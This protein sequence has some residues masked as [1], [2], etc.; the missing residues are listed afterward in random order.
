MLLGGSFYH[1]LCYCNI[2]W[3]FGPW[4]VVF[5][6]K[7][8]ENFGTNR[9]SIACTIINCVAKENADDVQKNRANTDSNGA[10]EGHDRWLSFATNG[11][12]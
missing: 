1:C 3:D 7:Q 8:E 12:H 11:S 5:V 4:V 10:L 6:Q 2:L 9:I